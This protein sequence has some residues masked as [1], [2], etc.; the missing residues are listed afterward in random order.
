MKSLK[1]LPLEDIHH[2]PDVIQMKRRFGIAYGMMV[3]L[4]FAASTW[5]IDGFLLSQAHAFYPWLKFILGALICMTVGGIAGW[6]VARL[7]KGILG[8][9]IYLGIS[10]V[11]SWLI[12]GLPFRIF[13]AVVTWLDPETGNLLNYTFYEGFGSR[14]FIAIAWISL[15][16]ALVGI[17][18]L[19]LTEP[20]PFATSFFGKA[21][22]L[23]VC[24]VIMFINGFIVDTLNNEP[25]RTAL[26]HMDNTIQFSV[27]HQG[28][29]VD[30]ALA[31]TMRMSSLRAVGDVISQP[32]RLIVGSYDQYLDQIHVLIRFGVTWVD[33]IVVYNQPSFCKYISLASP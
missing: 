32:R 5:G 2:R 17:L 9:L 26:L 7:E 6:L 20:A 18:Q 16:M 31:R 33:C 24:A 15:F 21:A 1:N 13:P 23:L 11:F 4:S 12:V 30:R 3:G 14:F 8:L 19:P 27:E 10:F 28:Q 22:P 25:L 29:E